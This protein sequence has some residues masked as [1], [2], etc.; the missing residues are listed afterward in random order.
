MLK[1][2]SI[3]DFEEKWEYA[4]PEAGAQIRVNRRMYYHHGIYTG[5]SVIHF[6]EGDPTADM[7]HS[8]NN[9]VHET[10]LKD[11]L[12]GGLLQV[13]VYS[14]GEKKLLNPP[15]KIVECARSMLGEGGYHF[16]RNN[17]EHFSNY[18]AFS[19][20]YSAQAEAH[21]QDIRQRIKNVS[22]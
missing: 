11:F 1:R 7:L 20:K 17:C 12:Q 10:S 14:R 8:E 6:G 3:R 4:Q 22:E 21:I 5:D 19:E 13:R 18:C 16:V 2:K 15:E 9:I